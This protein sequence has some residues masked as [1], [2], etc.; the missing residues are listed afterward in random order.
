MF[1]FWHPLRELGTDGTL[2]HVPLHRGRSGDWLAMK[3]TLNI[4]GVILVLF[5]G[6]WFFQGINVLPGSFM[7]GQVRWAIYGGIEFVGGIIFLVTAIRL[8]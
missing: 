1:L 4:F 8:S 7:T 2:K 5:G 6:I 3:S